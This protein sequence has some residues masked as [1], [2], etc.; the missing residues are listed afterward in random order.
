MGRLRCWVMEDLP[1]AIANRLP[2]KVA[3]FAFVRVYAFGC[4]HPGADYVQ[5]CKAWDSGQRGY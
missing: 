1:R 5:A 3:L 2:R 4:D